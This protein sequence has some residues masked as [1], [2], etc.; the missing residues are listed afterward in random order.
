MTG[1]TVEAQIQTKP[2][3][4]QSPKTSNWYYRLG[5]GVLGCDVLDVTVVREDY[6][7]YGIGDRI[8]ATLIYSARS[9][10]GLLQV[11]PL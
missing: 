11:E 7:R 9:G 5:L 1:I 6:E 4:Y 8:K 3:P 10:W 2:A